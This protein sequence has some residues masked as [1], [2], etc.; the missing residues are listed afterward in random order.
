MGKRK[1]KYTNLGVYFNS[2]IETS[3]IQQNWTE[4]INDIKLSAQ[5]WSRRNLSVDGKVII[6]KTFL[7]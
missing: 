4:Q 5:R 6:A 3:K 7:S 1:R 2:T